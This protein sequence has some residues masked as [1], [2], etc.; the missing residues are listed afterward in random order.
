MKGLAGDKKVS[1]KFGGVIPSRD[2]TGPALLKP[3]VRDSN[4]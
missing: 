2:S 3:G 1:P 4:T